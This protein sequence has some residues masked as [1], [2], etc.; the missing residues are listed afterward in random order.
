VKEEATIETVAPKPATK[1]VGIDTL[2][3]QDREK[4][5]MRGGHRQSV[6]SKRS[7]TPHLTKSSTAS[8][9]DLHL[10]S[11]DPVPTSMDLTTPDASSEA[12]QPPLPDVRIEER[13]RE[14]RKRRGRIGC[15]FVRANRGAVV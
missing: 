7:W 15:G 6:N 13:W 14:L 11:L 12:P 3:S 1:R 9:L 5:D 8:L 10:T 2:A 4:K